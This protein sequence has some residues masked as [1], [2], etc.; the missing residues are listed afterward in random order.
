MSTDGMRI[1]EALDNSLA[2]M[3]QGVSIDECLERHPDLAGELTPLLHLAMRT[4]NVAE[5]MAPSPEAQRAGLG[6]ITDEWN[7]MQSRSRNKG[8]W[9]VLRRS[10]VLAA[11]AALV[12]AFGGWTTASAAQDS[13]PGDTLYPVK[14]TQE[15]VLLLVVFTDGG[16]ADL[17]A[18]LAHER[19]VEATRLAAKGSDPLAVDE[20][21]QKMQDHMNECVSLMGGKLSGPSNNTSGVV[22]VVGPG[23]REYSLSRTTSVSGQISIRSIGPGLSRSDGEV[24][25]GGRPFWTDPETGRLRPSRGEWSNRRA[26]M[27]ERFYQQFLQFREGRGELSG[28]FQAAHRERVEAAFQRSETL[29]LEALLM[30]QALED[31]HHPPE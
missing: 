17:H 21:T 16:R 31:A 7:A 15:R 18:R 30:M 29:L 26:A 27:R 19:A 2:L 12:L 24:S 8:P 20:A 3:A 1:E 4:Q 25:I 10:W 14:Q 9:R 28:D 13:V 22:R 11:V 23:G 6:R 5:T